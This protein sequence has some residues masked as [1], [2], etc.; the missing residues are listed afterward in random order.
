M[1]NDVCYKDR[2]HL[3]FIP[4]NFLYFL[5]AVARNGLSLSVAVLR[6]RAKATYVMLYL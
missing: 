1:V 4:E 6:K 3:K 2:L 5:N